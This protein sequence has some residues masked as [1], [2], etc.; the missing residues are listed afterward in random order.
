MSKIMF[1][2]EKGIIEDYGDKGFQVIYNCDMCK[3]VRKDHIAYIVRDLD[4]EVIE[5]VCNVYYEHPDPEI[6]KEMV[7]YNRIEIREAFRAK[8]AVERHA[9]Q[10]G[11]TSEATLSVIVQ[12]K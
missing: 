10:I 3:E 8:T 6:A 9:I 1:R 2:N 4:A 12:G 7:G 11:L 5:E